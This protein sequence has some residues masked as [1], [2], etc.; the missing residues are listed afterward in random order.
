[1]KGFTPF[2][3]ADELREGAARETISSCQQTDPSSNG[4]TSQVN[5]ETSDRYDVWQDL[6]EVKEAIVKLRES[7]KRM[8]P[9]SGVEKVQCADY[10]PLLSIEVEVKRRKLSERDEAAALSYLRAPDTTFPIRRQRSPDSAALVAARD[11]ALDMLAA[12][13]LI[14]VDSNGDI[15]SMSDSARVFAEQLGCI[16]STVIKATELGTAPDA[17]ELANFPSVMEMEKKKV[18]IGMGM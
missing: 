9:L 8:S 6:C 5:E 12:M 15:K 2:K 4:H 17:E 13:N 7:R 18:R 14:T 11:N 1:M 10:E 3:M 16:Q